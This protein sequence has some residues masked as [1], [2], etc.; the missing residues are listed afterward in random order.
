MT[1]VDIPRL[2]DAAMDKIGQIPQGHQN[3]FDNGPKFPW[4]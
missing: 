4:T 2:A 3:G 1:Y